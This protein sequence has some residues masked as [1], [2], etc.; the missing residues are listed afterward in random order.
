MVMILEWDYRSRSPCMC[1]V[2]N[3]S[4]CVIARNYKASSYLLAKQVAKLGGL[5]D[6]YACGDSDSGLQG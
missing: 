1:G 6:R 3:C 4:A 5:A 2:S